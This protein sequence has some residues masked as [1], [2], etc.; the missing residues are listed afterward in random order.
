MDGFSSV[1]LDLDGSS[2]KDASVPTVS[3]IIPAY[4]AEAYLAEAIQSALDQ[5][6]A[7][8]EIIV[9]DD[10]S[11]DA[12][13]AI[14]RKFSSVRLIQQANGGVSKARNT[15][16][17][18]AEGEYLQF[19][20]ADDTLLP[21]KIARCMA[22]FHENPSADVVYCD[23]EIRS[24]D[25]KTALLQPDDRPRPQGRI[26]ETLIN[27][28]ASF[29]VPHCPLVK[30]DDARGVGGFR[31]N[32]QGVAD[33]HFWV[34]LAVAGKRFQH[35]PET[36]CWYRFTPQSMS[37]QRAAMLEDRLRAYQALHELNLPAA[38]PLDALIAGRHH[39][40][41]MHYWEENRRAAA[42]QHFRAAQALQFSLLRQA[43]Y[44]SSYVLP[45]NITKTLP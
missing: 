42:R 23:H 27:A 40:L 25:M 34:K 20:D 24:P 4:N 8:T 44:W 18:A 10:G 26:A 37:K 5:T 17:A 6:Y 29:W 3:I 1:P 38:I 45:A 30:K 31:E 19:L 36:L 35:M 11:T 41:A 12:T 28:T 2:M 32:L 7:D 33:W 14:A 39:A 13:P 16:I 43:W 22:A 15:G 21:E 9:V